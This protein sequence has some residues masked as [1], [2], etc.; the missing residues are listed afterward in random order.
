MYALPV[1]YQENPE[2]AYFLDDVTETRG[3]VFQPDVYA[4]AETLAE[5]TG[6]SRFIDI[7]C[8]WGNKLAD[9]HARH[10]GWQFLG[11]D[12]WDNLE[13]CRNEYDWGDWN[14]LDLDQPELSL[15]ATG[16]VVV[17]SDVIEH[18]AH[19]EYLVRALGDSGASVIVISTPERDVQHGAEHRGPSPNLCHVREWNAPELREFLTS[20]GLTVKFLGL[21]R[22]HD[23]SWIMPTQVVVCT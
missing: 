6:E 22:G 8:G 20:Q 17:C 11:I 14:N 21:T 5:L 12:F 10:P 16:A 23:Q 19:P 4:L 2:P 15:N 1:D 7:G 18:L 13:H 3:L 9:V